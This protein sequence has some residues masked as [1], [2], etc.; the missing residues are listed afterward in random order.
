M[1]FGFSKRLTLLV[2][3]SAAAPAGIAHAQSTEGALADAQRQ[4]GDLFARDRATSVRDRARPEY[5]ALGVPAGTFTAYPRLQVDAQYSDNVFATST[6]EQDDWTVRIKPEISLESGWS[7]HALGVYARADI[8]RYRDFDTENFE[9]WSVGGN[10]RIDIVRGSHL[11]AGF[12]HSKLTEPRSAAG[13]GGGSA[14][15][16]EYSSTSG[17]VSGTQAR[18][19]T[20]LSARADIR[21]LDYDDGRTALGAV[22][23]QDDRDR[24]ITSGALRG[25]LAISPATAVFAQVTG[26]NREYDSATSALLP[27]RDSSGYEALAGVNF[28]AGALARGE[29]AVGYIK[30]EFDAATYDDIDGFGA[31]GSL[32]WFPTELTT[33]TA[34]GSRTIEDAAIPGSGG[35]LSTALGVAVDHELLRNVLLAGSL[36]LSNDE[37]E[38]IDRTDDRKQA[39]VGATYLVNRVVGVSVSAT[40]L[41]QESDGAAAGPDYTVNTLMLSLV[42]Q[43]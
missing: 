21:T 6:N 10:G 25:D 43:F 13:I 23:N 38:G 11:A 18:G 16:I 5:E 4:T 20:K 14:E 7:R 42:A 3:I 9:D 28:E 41:E 17:Y 15:P 22:I 37:Y 29:I 30:Q 36:S 24:T 1:M 8:A 33:V 12:D 34:T 2:M 32:E 26:N 19:R 31:R 39:S 35:F 27:K 40:H